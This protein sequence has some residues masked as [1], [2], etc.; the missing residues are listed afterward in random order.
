MVG[1]VVNFR[2]EKGPSSAAPFEGCQVGK[3]RV[4]NDSCISD[5]E[6]RNLKLHSRWQTTASAR[7]SF[8]SKISDF[9]ILRCRQSFNL[10]N[11]L[12]LHKAKNEAEICHETKIFFRGP[13]K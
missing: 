8:L 3:F 2:V 13:R 4:L 11:Y 9:R 10:K 7:K 12:Y 6:T 1:V 5:P